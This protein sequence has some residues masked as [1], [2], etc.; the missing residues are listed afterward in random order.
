VDGKADVELDM[1][2][3]GVVEGFA[4]VAVLI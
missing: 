2:Y 4:T 3:I 1:P